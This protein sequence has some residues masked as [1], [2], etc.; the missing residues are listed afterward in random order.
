MFW[1]LSIVR[2]VCG[3]LIVRGQSWDHLF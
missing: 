2:A 3:S 1:G